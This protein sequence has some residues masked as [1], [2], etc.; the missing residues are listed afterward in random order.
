MH[1]CLL[2]TELLNIIFECHAIRGATGS[3]TLLS[4]AT[5]CRA[6][7]QP[8]LDILW[9]DMCNSLAPLIKC[10]PKDCWEQRGISVNAQLVRYL[11]IAS[12]F[13]LPFLTVVDI[14]V[15]A[16]TAYHRRL[17]HVE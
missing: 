9:R 11:M 15:L 6:F 3:S 5:T 8:A 2:V 13:A 17:V 10:L 4:L 16:E 12:I 14:L 7:Q 1:R